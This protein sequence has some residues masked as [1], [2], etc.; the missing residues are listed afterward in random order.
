MKMDT[1]STYRILMKNLFTVTKFYYC[2]IHKSVN[3]FNPLKSCFSTVNLNI[4]PSII[5]RFQS[6]PFILDLETEMC[7]N[8]CCPPTVLIVQPKIYREYTKEWWGFNIFKNF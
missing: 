7:L 6:W 4:Y 1:S 3:K 5:L 2:N 8:A